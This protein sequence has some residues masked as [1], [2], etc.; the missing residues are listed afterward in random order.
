MRLSDFDIVSNLAENSVCRVMMCR[1]TR[2]QCVCAIKQ[3]MYHKSK[4]AEREL[5]ALSALNHTHIMHMLATFRDPSGSLYIVAKIYP[6]GPLSLRL[7]K[8]SLF[9][10]SE[11]VH[12][13]AIPLT[14]ALA[15]MHGLGFLHRDV[16]PDNI[17]LTSRACVITGLGSS[18]DP[19]VDD[20]RSWPITPYSPDEVH[21]GEAPTQA[22]DIWACAHVL[23][24]VIKGNYS[25]QSMIILAN[26][27]M[28]DPLQRISAKKAHEMFKGDTLQKLP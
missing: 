10:E 7:R 22:S 1:Y 4:Q 14:S 28:K 13:L 3:Y 2:T 23:Y 9:A 20:G 21:D 16:R 8:K 5:H 25:V 12:T 27:H 19:C 6:L 24:R 11:A 17:L 18:V 15:Y 26:M